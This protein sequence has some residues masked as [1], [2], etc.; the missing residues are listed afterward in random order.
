MDWESGGLYV[1]RKPGR[2]NRQIED[3][4]LARALWD[5]T[6]ELLTQA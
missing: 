5:R 1:R 3:A 4:D 6:E 2:T